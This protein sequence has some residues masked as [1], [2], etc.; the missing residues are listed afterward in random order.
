MGDLDESVR[1][2]EQF[3]G[4]LNCSQAVLAQYAEAGGLDQELAMRIASGFGGGMGGLGETCGAVT[5]AVMAIGLV[6]AG[7][8]PRDPA[9]KMRTSAL[10]RAFLDEF[11]RRHGTCTCRALLGVDI[12]TAE[13]LQEARDRG[14]MQTQ[15]PEY[16]RDA[17]RILEEM[18]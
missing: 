9:D 14:L 10:V 7:P 15:C 12:G 2:V 8:E 6:T 16:V 11:R 4:G 13:G 5:G 17:V 3:M 18:V 1:A